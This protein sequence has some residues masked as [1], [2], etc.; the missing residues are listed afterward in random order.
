[1]ERIKGCIGHD[2]VE[3]YSKIINMTLDK[4]DLCNG[5]S[6]AFEYDIRKDKTKMIIQKFAHG[7]P[8]EFLYCKS[9]C[10]GEPI[11]YENSFEE[12]FE[13][14]KHELVPQR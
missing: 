9:Y 10:S 13:K 1:M 14:H 8:V 5:Y 11:V 7:I 6:V 2:G 3:R 4:N 12:E